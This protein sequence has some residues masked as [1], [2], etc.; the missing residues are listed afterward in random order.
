MPYLNVHRPEKLWRQEVKNAL[1][2]AVAD[3]WD[4]LRFPSSGLNPAGSTA[5]AIV[6][7]TT[8]MLSFAG[9]ADNIIGGIAQMPHAWKYA[10]TVRPHLHL[11]FPTSNTGKNTRW[12]FEYNRGNA[13]ENF[14]HAFGTYTALPIITVANPAATAK[15]VLAAFGD[16]DMAGYR[17]SACILWRITRM[18]A[19]DAADDDTN[20]AIL[21]EFDIHYQID[22]GGSDTEIPT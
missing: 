12:K 8:G 9:T 3:V 13:N 6:N 19:S 5:P 4:D 18:A 15:Q 21:L 17:G 16:L 20:A 22:K 2:G 14:E 1:E 7:T 11:M 10:S